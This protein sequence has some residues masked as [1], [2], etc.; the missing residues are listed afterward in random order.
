[1]RETEQ[2]KTLKVILVMG[3]QNEIIHE[4]MQFC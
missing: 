4:T 1:M 2:L 3:T